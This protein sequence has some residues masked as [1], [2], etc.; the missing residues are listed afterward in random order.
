LKGIR[1]GEFNYS[2]LFYINLSRRN[3]MELSDWEKKL[4]IWA[5]IGYKEHPWGE[6]HIEDLEI[7]IDKFSEDLHETTKEEN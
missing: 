2:L 6:D 1:F 7:L 5:L 4:T 3:L